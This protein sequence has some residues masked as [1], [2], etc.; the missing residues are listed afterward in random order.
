MG[1]VVLLSMVQATGSEQ[2]PA[3]GSSALLVLGGQ[4]HG[5]PG[6]EQE[7]QDGTPRTVERQESSLI[8]SP[9]FTE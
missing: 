7:S 9:C 6:H 2:W 4:G 1:R 3:S 8:A 5:C